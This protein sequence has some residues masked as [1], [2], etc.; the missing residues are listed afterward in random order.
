MLGPCV[1]QRVVSHNILPISVNP[2]VSVFICSCCILGLMPHD[3][4]VALPEQYV[5]AVPWNILP[6]GVYPH[7]HQNGPAAQPFPFFASTVVDLPLSAAALFVTA[8]GNGLAGVVNIRDDGQQGSSNVRVEVQMYHTRSHLAQSSQVWLERPNA[9][10]NG[11]KIQVSNRI[12][13]SGFTN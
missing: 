5:G 6:Q 2:D 9:G 12:D 7:P 10:R 1:A 3:L 13:I 4:A 8:Q 11:I